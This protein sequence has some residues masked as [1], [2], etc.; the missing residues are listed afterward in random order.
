[1]KYEADLRGKTF[2]V[3]IP[4]PEDEITGILL[5]EEPV[6][7]SM[8]QLP[9][10]R[11]ILRNNFRTHIIENI[12]VQYHEI[13]F[14]LDGTWTKAYLR[15]EQM[16]LLASLGFKVG[17]KQG[18]GKLTAPMPGK[19]LNLLVKEGEE[20][21]LGTPVV[22]LEAMKMENELKAPVAGKVAAIKVETGQSVEKNNLILEIEPV[23]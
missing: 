1:M 5:N 14:T 8:Q 15:D 12:T 19:I 23:G 17:A 16:L 9:D 10:G 11:L 6:K 4:D 7:V 20:V 2:T 22:I 18:E 3:D 13:E 21:E